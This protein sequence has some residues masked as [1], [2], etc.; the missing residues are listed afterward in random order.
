VRL[1]FE[2][3]QLPVIKRL[4]QKRGFINIFKTEYNLVN[5]GELH[6]FSSGTE[7]TPRELLGAGLIKSLKQPVKVLG[8]G[9]IS[10]PLLVRAD[11]F[12]AAAQ[13][14]ILAAGGKTERA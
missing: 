10:C 1:G 13:R 8:N 5:V 14:K 4:P 11:K 6:I 7:V 2:G 12:S 3:G 9:E